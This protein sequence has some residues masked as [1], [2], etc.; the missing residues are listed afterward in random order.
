MATSVVRDTQD[1][2]NGKDRDTLSRV[3]PEN[4]EKAHDPSVQ[5]QIAQLAYSYWL[6]RGCPSGSPEED[7]LQ[8]ELDVQKQQ[9]LATG[10]T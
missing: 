8:A 6:S 7:W 4:S 5:E 2:R 10:T 1:K 9:R 3:R